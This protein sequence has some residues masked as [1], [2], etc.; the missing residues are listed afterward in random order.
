MQHIGR[1]KEGNYNS[2]HK[3]QTNRKN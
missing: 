3:T 1:Q 2:F